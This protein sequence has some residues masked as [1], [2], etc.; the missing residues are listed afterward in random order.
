M[1]IAISAT[2]HYHAEPHD[3]PIVF[4]KEDNKTYALLIWPDDG[5]GEQGPQ[6]IVHEQGCMIGAWPWDAEPEVETIPISN[7]QLFQSLAP[8]QSVRTRWGGFWGYQGVF[9]VGK[10]YTFQYIGG[11]IPW[12]IPPGRRV[13]DPITF[14]ILCPWGKL[15]NWAR[16]LKGKYKRL[17]RLQTVDHKDDWIGL[18]ETSHDARPRI[19]IPASNAL[20]FMAVE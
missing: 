12:K 4:R 14:K 2:I 20:E 19:V 5:D 11:V 13:V 6:M 10:K 8:G 16:K 17:Y 9:Q 1:D 3:K 15:H 7:D 18:Y